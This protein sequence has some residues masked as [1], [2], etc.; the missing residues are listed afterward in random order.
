M[1]K[2]TLIC[3]VTGAWQVE[4]SDLVAPVTMIVEG[5]HNG[6]HGSIFWPAHVLREAVPLWVN[7]PVTLNHPEEDGKPVSINASSTIHERYTIGKVTNVHFDEGSK[8]LKGTVRIKMNNGNIVPVVQNCKE[9]SVGVFSDEQS[10]YGSWGGE[11]YS[12]CAISMKP[13]HLAILTDATGACSWKDGCGIRNNSNSQTFQI[14]REAAARAVEFLILKHQG[15]KIMEEDILLSPDVKTNKEEINLRKLQRE[16]DKDGI[17]LP[18]EYNRQDSQGR[19][20]D[21]GDLLLP[22]GF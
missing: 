3:N 15:G 2:Q 19:K 22:I 4:D 13:D 6:S 18:A 16:A 7:V 21:E 12:A 9:V 14:L 10:N 17:L 8:A 5:V 11:G 1:E 20:A